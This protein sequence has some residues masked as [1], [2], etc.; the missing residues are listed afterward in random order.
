MLDA[1]ITSK[2]RI[3]ILLKFFLNKSNKSYLRSLE[4]EFGESSNAIRIELNRFEEAGLLKSYFD[5]NKKYFQAN[6]E[7]PLFDDI[8]SMLL[9]M[10]GIDAIV[11]NIAHRL[12][13]VEAAYLAGNFARGIDSKMV[14]L[15]FIGDQ[16][17][18]KLMNNYIR[19]AEKIIKRKV[20]YTRINQSEREDYLNQ[21]PALLIWTNEK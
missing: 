3:K 13:H 12:E 21:T 1:L 16:V 9:K 20:R 6:T 14:D 4:Q 10:V 5:G 11:E 19:K 15:I 7:H 17:D 18:T 2:T 8:H